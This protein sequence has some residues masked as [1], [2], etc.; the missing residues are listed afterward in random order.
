MKLTTNE[1][2][3]FYFGMSL[4]KAVVAEINEGRKSSIA[5][6]SKKCIR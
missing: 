2:S 6:N 1:T 3:L 5:E 4:P